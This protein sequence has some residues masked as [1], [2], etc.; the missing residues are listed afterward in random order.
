MIVV[1]EP[2]FEMITCERCGTVFIPEP[3]DD[4]SSNIVM[5]D[6]KCENKLEIECPTCGT[7]HA[8]VPTDYKVN[9]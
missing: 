7:Y 2:V 3:K 6:G 1:R 5:Y 9:N 4:I 8:C